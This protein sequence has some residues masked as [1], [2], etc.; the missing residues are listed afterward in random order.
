MKHHKFPRTPIIQIPLSILLRIRSQQTHP[1][2]FNSH[3][4]HRL[5][6]RNASIKHWIPPENPWNINDFPKL[7]GDLSTRFSLPQG[8]CGFKDVDMVID[9]GPSLRTLAWHGLEN[10]WDRYGD[11]L[12]FHG[13]FMGI[14]WDFVGIFFGDLLVGLVADSHVVTIDLFRDHSKLTPRQKN[15]WGF[16]QI[17]TWVC[18]RWLFIFSMGNP[19]L[20]ESIGNIYIYIFLVVPWPIHDN[21]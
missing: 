8:L 17:T 9:A 19:L 10:H 2:I 16:G 7:Y 12:G 4:S 20:G 6:Q 3:I 11:L 15:P 18:G 1:L 13:D 21:I 14:S 5:K